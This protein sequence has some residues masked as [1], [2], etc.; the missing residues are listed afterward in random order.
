M[1]RIGRRERAEAGQR[2][3]R[4]SKR[5]EIDGKS[6]IDA[7]ALILKL[8]IIGVEL[9]VSGVLVDDGIS[10]QTNNAEQIV[11]VVG[12]V[13]DVEISQFEAKHTVRSHSS[14]SCFHY[15]ASLAYSRL[16]PPL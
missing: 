14:R 2:R 13:V 6:E 10:G 1:G 7:A 4:R 3:R 5:S 15:L 16:L 8:I 9:S 12:V 11:G